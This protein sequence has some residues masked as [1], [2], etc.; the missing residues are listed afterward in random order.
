[1]DNQG[2]PRETPLTKIHVYEALKNDRRTSGAA[3]SS[4][5]DYTQ[6]NKL[7]GVIENCSPTVCFFINLFF[8]CLFFIF[9]FLG[10][11]FNQC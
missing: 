3:A 6:F 8:F 11:A 2:A 1:M 5:P 10:F 7:L 4:M 9:V